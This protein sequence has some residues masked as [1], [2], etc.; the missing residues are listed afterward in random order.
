MLVTML[1]LMIS[2]FMASQPTPKRTPTE[3]K[4]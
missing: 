2:S 4:V 1:Q 3:I